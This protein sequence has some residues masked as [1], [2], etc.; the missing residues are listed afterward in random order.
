MAGMAGKRECAP[1][2]SKSFK[3]L[4]WHTRPTLTTL[5]VCNSK[6][7]QAFCLW[8]LSQTKYHRATERTQSV[9]WLTTHIRNARWWSTPH[10][11]YHFTPHKETSFHHFLAFYTLPYPLHH[12][13]SGQSF[14]LFLI[15]VSRK[16]SQIWTISLNPCYVGSFDHVL[17]IWL[18]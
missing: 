13:K 7:F 14:R 12:K 16:T 6:A 3:W 11:H 9:S 8:S 2:H 1:L 18:T 10:S 15:P 17:A 4:V 5:A